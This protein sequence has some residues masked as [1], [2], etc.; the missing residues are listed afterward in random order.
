MSVPH[1][2]DVSKLL[3]LY[4]QTKGDFV[5][6]SSKTERNW[7]SLLS[8]QSNSS[9]HGFNAENYFSGLS[10]M[11]N[12]LGNVDSEVEE[13]CNCTVCILH[14]YWYS[15]SSYAFSFL[16]TAK[17]AQIFLKLKDRWNTVTM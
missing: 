3:L 9:L 15:R 1:F 17:A 11:F 13:L 8:L 16:N 6:G 12:A 4:L 5:I 14:L 10:L 2:R 7:P